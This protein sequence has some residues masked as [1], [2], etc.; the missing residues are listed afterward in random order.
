MQREVPLDTTVIRKLA[1]EISPRIEGA[2]IAGSTLAARDCLVLELLAGDRL[3][4]VASTMR[5]MPLVFLTDSPDDVPP[6]RAELDPGPERELRNS[7]V[8]SLRLA[9]TGDV[10]ELPV[11]RTDTAGRTVERVLAVDLGR[12]PGISVRDVARPRTPPE[13][14]GPA[15][16]SDGAGADAATG[17]G[18][19]VAWR[20]DR[21]GRLHVRLRT[22]DE[23]ADADDAGRFE[24][25]NAFESANEAARFAFARFWDE[26]DHERR[27]GD[28]RRAI[29]AAVRR[30]RRAVGKVQ[31][32]VDDARKAEEYRAKG[33]LILARKD[34][35]PRGRTPIEV[36][37][38][39]NETKITID[40][41]PAL[42]PQR[43]AETLFRRAK[44]AERRGERA[45]ARLDEIETEMREL[46]ELEASVAEASDEE[47]AALEERFLR[48]AIGRARVKTQA[49]RARYRTY[50][51]SGGWQVLVGK[52][53][54]DNDVLSHRIARPDD[55]WFHAHQ[56]AGS[57]VVL[58]R[59]GRK[60]Q[61]DKRAIL[62]AAAIAAYHSKAGKS[63][64]VSV[65]YTEKR[66]VRKPRGARPGLAVV[67][68][69][70]V[71]M[72]EPKL[73]ET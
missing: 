37:D 18:A 40:V 57:H 7:R 62:E 19:T 54:R 32:E 21:S 64:K 28:V 56:S 52:S 72:V 38:F 49:A 61:P 42:D 20:H 1:D 9:G 12:K 34:S 60:E 22:D 11:A 73:P 36:L 63:S 16:G 17:S 50:T 66:H 71:V 15:D 47:L 51:V 23:R 43:N 70:K 27:R 33:Q 13:S 10:L 5:A 14:D 46:E 4:L 30:K 58:R 69:E 65:C 67:S 24:G 41:D 26:L 3:F 6:S 31:R 35:I 45:P 68:R 53:N 29:A 44:K 8:S 2:K 55:L 48:P 39:D 25:R 59:A